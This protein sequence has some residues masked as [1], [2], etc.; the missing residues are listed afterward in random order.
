MSGKLTTRDN[1]EALAER[2][3]VLAQP[4]RLMILS[5]LRDGERAVSEIEKTLGLKQPSL[6]QQLG[7]LRQARLVATRRQAKSIYYRLADERVDLLVRVLE[8]LLGEGETDLSALALKPRLASPARPRDAAI[9][10]TV[11]AA[12]VRAGTDSF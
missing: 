6:S 4:T 11:H 1:A 8:Q 12:K 3:R 9:F 5:L 2:L 10:A 7:E